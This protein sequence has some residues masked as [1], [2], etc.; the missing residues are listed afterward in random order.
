MLTIRVIEKELSSKL[1][2]ILFN[3]LLHVNKIS[4]ISEVTQVYRSTR[5]GQLFSFGRKDSNASAIWK[6]DTRN[7]PLHSSGIETRLCSKRRMV[8]ARKLVENPRN[9]ITY[10]IFRRSVAWY[11]SLEIGGL[12]HPGS[13]FLWNVLTL[14]KFYLCRISTPKSS[15]F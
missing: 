7:S 14:W 1:L 3:Q 4:R 10:P 11:E 8:C 15:C 5:G 2:D 12:K 13:L 6:V 9:R